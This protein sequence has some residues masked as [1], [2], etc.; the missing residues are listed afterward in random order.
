MNGKFYPIDF[1]LILTDW[2]VMI[3]DTAYPKKPT[4]PISSYHSAFY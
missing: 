2:S 3:S 1:M 4:R